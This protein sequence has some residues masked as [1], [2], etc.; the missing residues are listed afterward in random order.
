MATTSLAAL[1]VRGSLLIADGN[2]W[3]ITILILT[4]VVFI[5]SVATLLMY[6]HN[7]SFVKFSVS[8]ID[9]TTL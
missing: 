7:T 6:E 5:G 4:M 3:I 2:G 1:L 9:L 8:I